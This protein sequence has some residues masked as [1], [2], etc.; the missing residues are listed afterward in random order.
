MLALAQTL[1][2]L[3]C[4]TAEDGQQVFLNSLNVRI[5]NASWGVL[6]AAPPVIR[7]RVLH[8]ETLSLGEQVTF[9]HFFKILPLK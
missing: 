8:R 6:A 4:F 5:L 2:F 7:G 9:K 1:N 3:S